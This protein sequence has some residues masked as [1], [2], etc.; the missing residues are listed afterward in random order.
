VSEASTPAAPRELEATGGRPGSAQEGEVRLEWA[1]VTTNT[2]LI[3][4]DP[5]SVRGATV[6]RD[7]AAYKIYRSHRTNFVPDDT[8]NLLATV[9]AG[10]GLYS[11]RDVASCR[12]YS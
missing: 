11:D 7:L 3:E 1:P 9:P 8:T 5:D 4:G 6:I 2:G 12:S 10:M